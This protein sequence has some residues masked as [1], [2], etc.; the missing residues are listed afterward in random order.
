LKKKIEEQIE[1]KKQK[2]E[3]DNDFKHSVQDKNKAK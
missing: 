2:E 1:Q 3:E